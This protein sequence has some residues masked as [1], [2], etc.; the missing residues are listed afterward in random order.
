MKIKDK[1]LSLILILALIPVIA[2]ALVF[3]FTLNGQ[4]EKPHFIMTFL[5]AFLF[6]GVLSLIAANKGASPISKFIKKI[7]QIEKGD[8][9]Q[10]IDIKT[11]DEIETLA[12]AFNGMLE[13]INESY[14]KIEEQKTVLEVRIRAKTKELKELVENLDGQI[15]EKTKELQKRVDELE[16]F[17][18]LTIGR[19]LKMTELKEEIKKLKKELDQKTKK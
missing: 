15:K 14:E 11:G 12:K 16:R 2:I 17:Q 7:Q 6:I 18:K 5:V 19:E 10:K 4:I 9:K 1:L 8:L 3:Y 13:K